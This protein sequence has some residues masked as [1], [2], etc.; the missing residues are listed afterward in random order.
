MGQATLRTGLLSGIV[1]DPSGARVAHAA[2]RL[3]ATAVDCSATPSILTDDFGRFTSKVPPGIYNLLVDSPGFAPSERDG[4]AV[5]P[6]GSVELIL[7]LTISALPESVDVAPNA[8]LTTNAADNRSAQI[9]D[10]ERLAEL[11]SD[12]ATFQQQLNVLAGADP[13]HPAEIL[14]DGF[15]GGR[16]PPKN[17][18]R[19]VRINQ[20]PY[21]AQFPGYG[22]N[23]IEITTKP[24][25]GQFHGSLQARGM[26]AISTAITPTPGLSPPITPIGWMAN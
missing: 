8:S 2:V 24:G 5:K 22:M 13:S 11:S 3:C 21:S 6:D 26:T 12:D 9:F 15:S 19:E 23:R 4:V 20:N 1:V 17:N 14:V 16:I 18:I 25:G 10:E 7:K